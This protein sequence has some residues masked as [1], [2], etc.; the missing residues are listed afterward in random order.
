MKRNG[1]GCQDAGFF[2]SGPYTPIANA[3]WDRLGPGVYEAGAPP[4]MAP[5]QWQGLGE[6]GQREA[7]K[8]LAP[9]FI[10]LG[11]LWLFQKSK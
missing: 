11:L 9:L 4:T 3:R 6:Q 5:N 7:W 2:D 1:C 8:E 10:G